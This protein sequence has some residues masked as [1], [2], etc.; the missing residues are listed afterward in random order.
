MPDTQSQHSAMTLTPTSSGAVGST[1]TTSAGAGTGVTD[2]QALGATAGNHGGQAV[3]VMAYCQAI[4]RQPAL[5]ITSGTSA[6]LQNIETRLN[7]ALS[8]AW[9]HANSYLAAGGLVQRVVSAIGDVG[10]YVNMHTALTQLLQAGQGSDSLVAELQAIRSQVKQYEDTATQLST[11]LSDFANAVNTDARAFQGLVDDLNTLVGGDT[12]YLQQLRTSM[13]DLDSK[14]DGAITGVVLSGIAVAG[15]VIM[16]CVG[17]IGDVVTGGAATGLVLAGGGLL[18]AGAG[19]EAASAVVL[20]KLLDEKST[21]LK[22]ETQIKADVALA[23]GIE[24]SYGT[25]ASRAAAA[26]TAAKDMANAWTSLGSDMDKLASDVASAADGPALAL[27]WLTA[28][29][30]QIVTIQQD[31]TTIKQ[32]LSS[33]QVVSPTGPD[34][35]GMAPLATVITQQVNAKAA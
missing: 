28:A 14:I 27:L 29:D 11:D 19:G 24:S 18:V 4:A 33:V 30:N 5:T 6:D 8:G 10:G 34:G 22:Q 13:G 15:G 16:I 31:V 2:A 17:A 35:Q 3:V 25:L 9:G 12:G 32:Q 7:T 23:V 20:T 1:G 21:L 26:A